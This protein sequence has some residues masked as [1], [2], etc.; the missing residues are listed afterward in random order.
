MTTRVPVLRR[1]SSAATSRPLMCG[2][3][4][5]VMKTSGL[6]ASTASS[7]S[8]P[9]R[10]CA[11]TEISPSI[12]SNAARAPSTIP[13]SSASTTRILLRAFAVSL[14]LSFRGFHCGGLPLRHDFFQRQRNGEYG[15]GLCAA[16]QRAAKHLNSFAHASQPVA[17]A[18][19]TAAA[20]VLNLEAA[21]TVLLFEAHPAR[22]RLRVTHNVS[23]RLPHG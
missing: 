10:A 16:I 11:T 20:V 9:L 13:W 19:G 7:A 5:S 6:C 21:G 18:V 8:L 12:S 23:D 14:T 22:T 15:A 3:S 17:F 2:I 4:M 1:W